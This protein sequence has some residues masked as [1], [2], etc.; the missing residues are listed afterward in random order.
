[1][2][3]KLKP[4]SRGQSDKCL[5][6]RVLKFSVSTVKFEFCH[7]REHDAV[8][9]HS[10]GGPNCEGKNYRDLHENLDDKLEKSL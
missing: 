9:I 4:F 6:I 3:K 10:S 1:M 7:H 5:K 8:R 2:Y